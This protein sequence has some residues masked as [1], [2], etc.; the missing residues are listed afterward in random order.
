MYH[1]RQ[2]R[3]LSFSSESDS[4]ASDSPKQSRR[5]RRKLSVSP[6]P[7][8]GGLKRKNH[9]GSQTPP[10]KRKRP[11]VSNALDDPTRKYCLGKLEE[12]FRDIFLRYPH[13]RVETQGED[14][15][16]KVH[17]TNLVQKPLDDLTDDE[18]AALVDESK[19]FATELEK[20]VFEIYSEP[21]KLGDPSAGSKY[22]CVS[23][24]KSYTFDI[25]LT[26]VHLGIVLGCFNLI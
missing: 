8:H 7:N 6:A 3:R 2:I 13:I 25:M 11:D 19:Q 22:K 12:L 17:E 14:N 20:C 4:D 21:D 23:K 24:C 9:R 18:K 1:K 16:D 10:A 26:I 15:H 5:N